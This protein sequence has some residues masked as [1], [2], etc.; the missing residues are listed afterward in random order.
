MTE[1]EM[2]ERWVETWKL[3]GPELEAIR[4]REV[5]EADNRKVLALI[6]GAFNPCAS[7][8]AATLLFWFGRDARLVSKAART[9]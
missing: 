9:V 8:A 5:R 4:R 3:A 6:E 7:D 1:R 2:I